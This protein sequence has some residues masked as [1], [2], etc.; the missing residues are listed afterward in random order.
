MYINI[1]KKDLKRKKTMNI[2]L[3]IFITLAVTFISSSVNNMTSVM[4]A[5][6]AYMDK[7]DAPEYWVGLKEAEEAKKVMDFLKEENLEARCQELYQAEPDNIWVNGNIM[8]SI[9]GSTFVSGIENT[10]NVFDMN[11]EK[12]EKIEEG[13]IYVTS[14]FYNRN[15]LKKG[16]KI[17][18]TSGN[19]TKTYIL[20]GAV[21]DV[22]FGSP[23]VGMTRFLINEKDY[24]EFT[25]EH[26]GATLYSVEIHTDNVKE[27]TDTINDKEFN[28][29]FSIDESTIKSLYIMDMI[30]A[31]IMFIVSVC[32]IIISLIILKFT[33]NF[34]MSEEYREIGVIKA[35]GIPIKSTRRIY[36]AKYFMIA[37][38]GGIIGIIISIPFGNAMMNE[39]SQNMIISGDNKL[40][41]NIICGFA[42]VFLVAFFGYLCTG[43][44]KKIKPIN[45][46]RNGSDGKR[47]KK[48][49][50]LHI[51]NAKIGTSLFMAFNDIL[52]GMKRYITMVI[53]FTIGTLLVIIPV[54]TINTLKSDSLI[55]WFSM[56]KSDVV[57]EKE[58]VLE[59]AGESKEGYENEIDAVKKILKENGIEADVFREMLFRMTISYNGRKSTSLAFQGI[60][61]VTTDMYQYMEGTSPENDDEVGLSHII[62]DRIGAEIGDTVTINTG[63]D[64]KEYMVT[65]IFQTMNNM[66][67]GIRFYQEKELDYRYLSSL[68][69]I[70]VRYTDN[71]DDGESEKRKDILTD[72]FSDYDVYTCG[73]YVGNMIGGVGEQLN[74]IKQMILII[75]VCINI[76]VTVLMVKSFITKEK[77]EIG[78]LKAIGFRNSNLIRWQSYRIGIVLAVSLFIGTAVSAPLSQVTSG[79]VFK[80]MGAAKIEFQIVPFE[81]YFLYPVII[82]ILTVLSGVIT[83][84]GLRKIKAS[85]TSNIE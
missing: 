25:K 6:D 78:M 60:G 52:S 3:F 81:V 51:G 75:V 35:I 59:V 11:D 74:G 76:L 58:Q 71:P 55:S 84:S 43:K 32:L 5:L 49:G 31:A 45:A 23:M 73:E 70:Q 12:I 63:T 79:Q 41:I 40:F 68:F 77:G 48:K 13:Q 50:V 53:I 69:A 19:T 1:L 46:I 17:T 9:L 47:Y 2:I 54:N 39:L 10:V 20:A 16:D 27:F 29:I 8:P 83:A 7:S 44:I 18:I 57:L 28:T 56:V 66:G 64:T 30:I 26:M 24:K 61:D 22:L 72:I 15:N 85:E 82:F 14:V 36:T 4:T 67:E 37:A 65:A 21:K 34:T 33:I 80:M 62:A 38:A 42:I